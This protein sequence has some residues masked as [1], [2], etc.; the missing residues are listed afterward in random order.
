MRGSTI[1][2]ACFICGCGPA[3]AQTT[4]GNLKF[5]VA[6]VRPS[7]SVSRNAPPL[8]AISGGPGTPDPERITYSRVPMRL[9]L[10]PAFGLQS[11]MLRHDSMLKKD[12]A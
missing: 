2:A 1:S 9:I 7:G 3:L 5:E 6:S 10:P 12:F 4:G 8:G 11:V